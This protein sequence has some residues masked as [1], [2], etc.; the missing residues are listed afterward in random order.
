MNLSH[1]KTVR[2]RV[3]FSNGTSA[4]PDL[5]DLAKDFVVSLNILR[6]RMTAED[7]SFEIEVS[8][9][10]QEIKEFIRMIEPWRAP[11]GT[12]PVEVA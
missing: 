2:I 5:E 12:S 11:V 8:G 3:L 7:A 9:P 4:R 1:R 10:A 6:G